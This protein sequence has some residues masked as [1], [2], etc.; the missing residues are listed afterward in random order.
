MGCCSPKAVK[1]DCEAPV[2]PVA[3]CDDDEY[4]TIPQPDNILHPFA[5]SARL[6]DENCEVIT[7]ESGA[8]IT[9]IIS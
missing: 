6:F 7:D 1:T 3:Q 5:I 4:I 2:L 9:L 8:A